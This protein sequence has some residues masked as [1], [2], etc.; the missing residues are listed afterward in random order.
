MNRVGLHRRQQN[1][2]HVLSCRKL[3]CHRRKDPPI[4]RHK[5]DLLRVQLVQMIKNR[6]A[7][8]ADRARKRRIRHRRRFLLRQLVDRRAHLG[9]LRSRFVRFG[10]NRLR[11]LLGSRISR[12]ILRGLLRSRRFL[13][14]HSVLCR[15]SRNFRCSRLFLHHFRF[16]AASAQSQQQHRKDQRQRAPSKFLHLYLPGCRQQIPDHLRHL[17]AANGLARPELCPVRFQNTMFRAE[18]QRIFCVA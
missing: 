18:R 2:K 3:D 9:F 1:V 10:F 7:A 6:R 8:D 12:L 5:L 16:R 15:L 11:L 13:R 14:L 17:A 4:L